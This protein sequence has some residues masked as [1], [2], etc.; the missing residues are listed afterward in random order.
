VRLF[1]ALWDAYGRGR[2]DDA[3]DVIDPACELRT[4]S[5]DRVY[6]GHDGVREWLAEREREWKS[7]TVSYDEVVELDAH[8]IVAVGHLTAFDPAGVQVVDTSFAWLAEFGEHGLRRAITYRTREE[9][10]AGADR[11]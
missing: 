10:M 2:V 3:L 1:G 6:R 8:R 11:D 5:S 9:A 4:A 7:V